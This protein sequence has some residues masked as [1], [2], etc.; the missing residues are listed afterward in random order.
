MS[1]DTYLENVILESLEQS[2]DDEARVE[3]QEYAKKINDIAY[4]VESRSVV[5]P[6][7]FDSLFVFY[8]HK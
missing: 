3:I 6:T 2:A 8:P 4:K 1:V 5:H 7:V